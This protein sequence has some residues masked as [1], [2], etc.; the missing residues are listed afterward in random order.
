MSKLPCPVLL[1]DIGIP[2]SKRPGSYCLDPFDIEIPM[3][4][5]PA[6]PLM[7]PFDIEIPM[8]KPP[9]RLWIDPFDIENPMSKHPNHFSF[10]GHQPEILAAPAH[11]T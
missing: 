6:S 10:G 5:P 3:S 2:M 4:K 8:S 7:D 9:A 1:G 11:L